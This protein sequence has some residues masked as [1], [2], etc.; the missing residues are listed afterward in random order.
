MMYNGIMQP[1]LEENPGFEGDPSEGEIEVL[2]NE[3]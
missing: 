2:E 3:L 1:E